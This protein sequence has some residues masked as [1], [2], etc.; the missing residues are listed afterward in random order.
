VKC[1]ISI[2][3]KLIEEINNLKYKINN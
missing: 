3:I 1:K 2:V